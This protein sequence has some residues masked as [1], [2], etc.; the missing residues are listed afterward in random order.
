MKHFLSK[1]DQFA[2]CKWLEAN[3]DT[4]RHM[5]RSGIADV[6]AKAL[7]I[8]PT[9]SNVKSALRAVGITLAQARPP[10]DERRAALE[11]RVLALESQVAHLSAELGVKAQR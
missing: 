6:A 3:A 9:D 8:R 2:F 1:S 11:A 5:S 7:N 4:V 10:G